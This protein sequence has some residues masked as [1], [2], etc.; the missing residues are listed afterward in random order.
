M[1]QNI[2]MSEDEMAQKLFWLSTM[3][4][5]LWL[6]A[7]NSSISTADQDPHIV[8]TPT[9]K[10]IPNGSQIPDSGDTSDIT[11]SISD[12]NTTPSQDILDEVGY[13]GALLPDFIDCN[14]KSYDKPTFVKVYDENAE[15][16]TEITFYL[17]GFSVDE[18]VEMIVELPNSLTEKFSEISGQGVSFSY[19]PK[20]ND[21]VGV[22]HFVFRD[23]N[24]SLDWSTTVSGVTSPHLYLEDNRLILVK[25]RPE[26]SVRLFIY[27]PNSETRTAKL[28]GW[29]DIKVDSNGQLI[30]MLNGIPGAFVAVGESTGEVQF[31]T[32]GGS[33][34]GFHS[35]ILRTNECPNVGNQ[36]LGVDSA[37]CPLSP[38]PATPI[39]PQ[40]ELGKWIVVV[41]GGLSNSEDAWE[42]GQQFINAGYSVQVFYRN[43]D[44]RVAVIGFSSEA[45]ANEKLPKI[46]NLNSKA[47]LR[48]LS[49]WCPNRELYSDHI[50]CR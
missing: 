26:E 19:T 9:A 29:K 32:K 28:F 30:I 45:D 43:D 36:G 3:L 35:S 40:D 16:M 17:C 33:L 20:F 47:Y 50:V 5:L 44:I 42:Y 6:S 10:S 34:L 23:R 21:P 13:F 18:R 37:D 49:E 1:R 4:V 12:L 48:E 2:K 22:Y 41:A 15:L 27:H 14:T 8:V 7:C 11:L 24:F 46:Q 38:S 39:T 31:S 25:F